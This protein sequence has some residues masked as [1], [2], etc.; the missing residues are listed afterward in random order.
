VVEVK[1]ARGVT[2]AAAVT[3]RA[4]AGA[5]TRTVKGTIFHVG[6]QPE[7]RIV[8]IDDFVLDASPEGRL[9]LIGNADRPGV[10]G[11]VGTLLGDRGINVARLHVGRRHGG[12]QALMLWQVDAEL[13][14]AF[15]DEVRR[16]ANVESAARVIL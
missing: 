10:I 1:R 14:D 7:P 9:L 8:Q 15:L 4:R 12:S 5:G 2:F 11:R 13:D 16:V 3:L 6:D